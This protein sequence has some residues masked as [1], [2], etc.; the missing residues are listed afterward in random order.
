MP[1]VP[2]AFSVAR[3]AAL[4]GAGWLQQRRLAAA[5]AL[6]DAELPSPSEEEWRY[7]PVGKLR[8]ETFAPASP[9]PA[10]GPGGPLS[11]AA[12]PAAASDLLGSLRRRL[13]GLSALVVTCDG[14]LAA[15]EVSASAE[16]EGLA[17][18]P[19]GEAPEP[20][21]APGGV[22]SPPADVFGLMNDAFCSAPALLEVPAGARLADPVAV[23]NIVTMPSLAAFPRLAV[24]VGD[25][26]EAQVVN[27][28][29]SGGDEAFAAPVTEIEVGPSAR[30]QFLNLQELGP[31][32]IGIDRTTATVAAQGHLAVGFAA[33]G[34][35]Y[36][37]CRADC[38]LT[39]RGGTGDMSAMYFGDGEQV[40]DF[41]TFQNHLAPDTTSNLLFVGAVEDRARS[42]YSG[43]IRVGAE[44]RGTDAQQTN[45]ILK[46]SE[47][48]WADSVP[49]LEI[50]N[51]DVRCA[52]ASSVGPIDED[53]RFYLES[54]GVPPDV[55]ERLIVEGFFGEVRGRLPVQSVAAGFDEMVRAK[56]GPNR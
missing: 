37:R 50:E 14:K 56:I 5:E 49:N 39:G 43:L 45:R 33:V 15:T 1:G 17:V 54:R 7:S 42:I 10:N 47:E 2:E 55:A 20:A 27:A 16:A 22:G 12:L 26:A 11:R 40:L 41:R 32:A 9:E 29:V 28:V 25:G 48:V 18:R 52:H 38:T 51:N 31:C 24:V 34:G 44:A 19:L 53:H 36:A 6:Q 35:A 4:G 3:A 23:V 30:L 46:L 8:L 13:G 21:G